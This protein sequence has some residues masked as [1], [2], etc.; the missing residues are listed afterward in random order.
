MILVLQEF[1]PWLWAIA[2]PTKELVIIIF[3]DYEHRRVH[4]R[5]PLV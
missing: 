1:I 3:K 4:C 2:S 5:G